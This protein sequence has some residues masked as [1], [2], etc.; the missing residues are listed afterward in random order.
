[1]SLKSLKWKTTSSNNFSFFLTSVWNPIWKLDSLKGKQFEGRG[2]GWG[3]REVGCEVK[4]LWWR[5]SLTNVPL[6]PK[7]LRDSKELWTEKWK[8]ITFE[9]SLCTTMK[10]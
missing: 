7:N 5:V 8:N 2:L 6:S 4:G 1:L 10:R 9:I 3:M